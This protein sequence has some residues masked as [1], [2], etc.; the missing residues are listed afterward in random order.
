M[1]IHLTKS[2]NGSVMQTGSS[3]WR[4]DIRNESLAIAGGSH[5]FHEFCQ[6]NFHY[7]LKLKEGV[8]N[9]DRCGISSATQS[10]PECI[11]IR[12]VSSELPVNSD[13]KSWSTYSVTS[14]TG[15]QSG[16]VHCLHGDEGTLERSSTLPWSL[17]GR[18][19]MENWNCCRACNHL[20]IIPSVFLN[21][22]NHTNDLSSL[23]RVNLAPRRYNR[24]WM[25]MATAAS[26]SRL[27][28]Q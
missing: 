24:N 16:H 10:S 8:R 11:G 15:G 25:H 22:C 20:A 3:F 13:S 2:M 19:M 7:G 4:A 14:M 5:K 1:E 21:Q 26:I 12:S 28:V 17:P 23:R 9:L 18:C 6:V 27:V